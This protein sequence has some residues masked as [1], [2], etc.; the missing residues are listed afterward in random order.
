VIKGYLNG[1]GFCVAPAIGQGRRQGRN[2]KG[3]AK[4]S[5]SPEKEGKD[6]FF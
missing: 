1:H 2:A 4:E 6:S 5:G 3:R